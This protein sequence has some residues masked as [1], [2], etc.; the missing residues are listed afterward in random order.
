M[1]SLMTVLFGLF[2]AFPCFAEH[3][4]GPLQS[5][6]CPDKVKCEQRLYSS[7]GGYSSNQTIGVIHIKT[8]YKFP[9]GCRPWHCDGDKTNSEYWFNKCNDTFPECSNNHAGFTD[10]FCTAHFETY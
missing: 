10:P 4:R 1:H 9:I 5:Y 2:L 7:A 8:C 6:N 3:P